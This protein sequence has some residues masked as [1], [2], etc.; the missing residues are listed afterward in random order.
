MNHYIPKGYPQI[1]PYFIVDGADQ[2]IDFLENVFDA[3]EI[4]K[5]VDDNEQ[6]M[7]AAYKVGEG[8]IE[9]G[10]S[11]EKFPARTNTIHIYVSNIDACYEKAVKLGA[12]TIYEPEDM[13]YGERSAGIADPFDNQWFIATYQG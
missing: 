3:K 8:V 13:P 1:M 7:H 10:N 11:S 2:F 4:E 6:I 5:H 9:L 12:A